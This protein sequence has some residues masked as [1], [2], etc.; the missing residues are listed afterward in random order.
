MTALLEAQGLVRHFGERRVVDD[1][2]LSLDAGQVLGLLGPNGAGK[3]TTF[4]MIAGLLKPDRG[5]VLLDGEEITKLALHRRAALGLGYLAQRGGLFPGL[6]VRANLMVAGEIAGLSSSDAA[7]RANELIERLKL[8]HVTDGREQTLSGGERRRA[9]IARAL[10]VRPRV[11]LFDEP[12]A[13]VD[14]L[15][16]TSLQAEMRALASTGLA[17]LITDHAVAA[18]FSICDRVAVLNEGR[19]L[20]AGAPDVV[21]SDPRV[22]AAYLGPKDSA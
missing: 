6:D 21:E 8:S 7:Q 20:V 9:E 4:R 1:I 22:R 16:V 17:I 3:T 2:S 13:G 10:M 19:V 14:P 15:A 5:R 11:L 12:F 18:T